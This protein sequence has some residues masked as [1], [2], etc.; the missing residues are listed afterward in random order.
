MSSNGEN[1]NILLMTNVH[2]TAQMSHCP[3]FKISTPTL[4]IFIFFIVS[5]QQN[6]IASLRTLIC[7]IGSLQTVY[8]D[9]RVMVQYH[10]LIYF[11]SKGISQK[12]SQPI[13]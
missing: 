12:T 7:F 5:H 10:H 13:K 8:M 2:K 3:K 9:M 1:I 6:S 11:F 4:L